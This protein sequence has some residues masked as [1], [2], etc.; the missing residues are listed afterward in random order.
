MRVLIVSESPVERL[1]AASGLLT[2]QDVEV[3][4]AHT[5]HAAREA[6]AAG[7][8][9]VL[10]IDG[11]LSPEGGFSL[12]YQIREDGKLHGHPTP[13]CLVVMGR[14]QDR[15]LAGWSGANEVL[16]KPVEP[17]RLAERVVALHGVDA[18]QPAAN[19]SAAQ[20]EEAVASDLVT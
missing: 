19:E 18:A 15:W 10:V 6:V 4:E 17:F 1:R 3:A 20:V 13:P 7:G 14:E 2:S 16:L 11:D 9:D 8:V 12:L 5:A